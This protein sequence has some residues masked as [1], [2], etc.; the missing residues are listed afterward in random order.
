MLVF[1][2]TTGI[3]FILR[4]EARLIARDADSPFTPFGTAASEA[5][6]TNDHAHKEALAVEVGS[7]TALS[8]GL[9]AGGRLATSALSRTSQTTRQRGDP[10]SLNSTLLHWGKGAPWTLGDAVEGTLVLGAT[11]SGKSSGPGQA[12]IEAFLSSGFGGLVLTA[13][14]GEREAWEAHCRRYGRE[15]DLIV[16]GSSERWR[17][18]Y[19]DR[20][21]NR[22]GSG[23]GHTE[24]IV[25]LFT[26]VLEVAERNSG[27]GSG[28][29]DEAYWR[30]AN[31]QLCRNA[32]DLLAV[33]KG[34]VSVPDLYRLIV[35]APTSIEQIRSDD[36]RKSSF[37]FQCLGEADKRPKSARQQSDFALVADYFMLEF[38][39]LSDKTRSVIVS[40]FTSMV[41]VLNR[42]LL[43]E[44][45]CEDSNT[46]P[47]AIEDGKIVLVDLPVKDFAEIGQFAQVI[48]KY[49]FQR[50]IE[51]RDVGRNPRPVFLWQDEGQFF[52][53]SY[54]QQFQ[55]T[56]RSSRVATVVLT[57]NVSNFYAALG[58]SDQGRAEA[59]SLFANL[60]TKF[61]CANS[62]PVTNEWG[63]SLIG[64]TRQFFVNANSSNPSMDWFDLMGNFGRTSQNSGGVSESYEYE[65][66]PSAFTTLRT[67]GEKNNR[68][69]DAILFQNGKRF[70]STG[71]TWMPV[72]F[73]QRF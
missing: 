53:T 25:N 8:V 37:C 71:R 72:T 1:G 31:R 13:K 28:R 12:M 63:A 7:W 43:R 61:F 51:R 22:P 35:S 24:N 40:T 4:E 45:F 73:Q 23:A 44:L 38:P 60:N 52:V 48:W 20:E 16:F 30:R 34:R 68:E 62:D 27:Q 39:G 58:G 64:R 65:V 59:D 29:G 14:Q 41:D 57:Q 26:T 46:S 9:L 32:V 69:V 49:S 36:W 55:T 47:E 2:F 21:L 50:S 54:D 70:P 42:G 19:L 66:Q 3:F 11:G 33:A 67:G 5:P 6:K 18:N 15:S 56:C 17:Y 10:Q